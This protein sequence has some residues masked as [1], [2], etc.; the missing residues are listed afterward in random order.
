MVNER[1][2]AELVAGALEFLGEGGDEELGVYVCGPP[3]M[4]EA[5]VKVCSNCGIPKT[6][7]LYE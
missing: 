4:P 2:N 1:V 7:V 5:M 6:N 3:G